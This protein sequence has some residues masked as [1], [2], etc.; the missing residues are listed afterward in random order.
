[1]NVNMYITSLILKIYS[2]QQN[3]NVPVSQQAHEIFLSFK[4]MFL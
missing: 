2:M 4:S 1:M 3:D